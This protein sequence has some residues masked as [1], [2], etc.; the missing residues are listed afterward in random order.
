MILIQNPD[1]GPIPPI[2]YC[3]PFLSYLKFFYP[4]CFLVDNCFLCSECVESILKILFIIY[5]L[6]FILELAQNVSTC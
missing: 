5:Y 3:I 2:H 1:P 4:F 6:L